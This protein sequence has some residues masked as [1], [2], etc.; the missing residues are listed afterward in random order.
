[1]VKDCPTHGHFED[2]MSIDTEFTK[3]L[4]DVFPGRDI[5]AHNDEHLHHHGSSTIK[6]GR[7]SV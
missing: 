7:G 3:H 2:V 6:Y 4:E 1:M 5:R